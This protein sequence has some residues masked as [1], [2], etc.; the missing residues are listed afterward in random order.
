MATMATPR[1]TAAEERLVERYLWVLDFVSRCAQA[2]DEGNWYYLM[3]KAGQ[4][5]GAAS[6]LE[7]ELGASRGRP[8]VR[9][10]AVL[11]A[12]RFHGR[13]YRAS[14]LLHPVQVEL[15]V[16]EVGSILLAVAGSAGVPADEAVL[17]ALRR[18]SQG[19]AERTDLPPAAVARVL[20]ALASWE[21][22]DAE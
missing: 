9:A 21:V 20:S 12:V 15:T 2:V 7:E 5:T 6:R 18:D 10:E 1:L 14:R 22:R 16:E 17:E 11:A 8:K 13:H 19:I 3:D 4:L